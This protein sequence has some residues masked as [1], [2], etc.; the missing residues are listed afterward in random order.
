MAFTYSGNPESSSLD[1]V[2]SEIGDTNSSEPLLHDAE[3][4][5]AITR[6][7]NLYL[8]AAKCAGKIAALFAR[9][10]NVE[11][12][13][14]R[15]DASAMFDHY[16]QLEKDLRAEARR[17]GTR[18]VVGRIGPSKQETINRTQPDSALRLK[19]PVDGTNTTWG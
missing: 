13:K 9:R 1:F 15:K 17:G 16:R 8:A 14:A 18:S 3:I 10:V 2:R 19:R 11:V 6:Q 12:G 4:N 7:P 5:S